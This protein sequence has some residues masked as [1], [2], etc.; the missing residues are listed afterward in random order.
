[1]DQTIQQ[2]KKQL[3]AGKK[4][5]KEIAD[6]SEEKRNK[7]LESYASCLVAN[8]SLILKANEKDMIFSRQQ[9]CNDAFLDR[10]N[11]TQ[12]KIKEMEDE[13]HRIS[14]LHCPIG[15]ELETKT[16]AN[17]VKLSKLL[18]PLGSILIIY[19]SRP[20]VTS[21]S[22]ALCLKSG[23]RVI[24]KGGSESVHTNKLLHTLYQDVLKQNNIATESAIFIPNSDRKIIK[25][26]VR[27]K[28]Y[29]DIIIP[30]GGYG[31]V[32]M[33][34]RTSLIPIL[35]H[36]AGGARIYVDKSADV[37]M[38]IDICVNSKTNRPATC[39][40]LDTLIVHENIVSAILPVITKIMEQKGV[41]IFGDKK[42]QR[43]GNF[44]YAKEKQWMQE[45]L[46]FTLA[47]K[48]VKDDKEALRFIQK[49]TKHH[50]EGIVAQNSDVIKQFV[51]SIDAAALCINCSTRLHD[52]GV[53]GMGAEMGIATGKLHARGPVGLRELLTYKW[54][55]KG[56]GQ[57]R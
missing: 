14:K 11:L 18:V 27:Q 15:E 57:I 23:N 31:L 21:Y 50:T 42:S 2:I 34:E 53:F 1:M 13:L 9:G 26:L 49:Y 29:I 6:F 48:I 16:L 46:S 39:N 19:E 47:I 55:L 41:K 20:D 25:W 3:L 45:F 7:I 8:T 30:R 51:D 4:S 37:K 43:Y 12:K 32:K 35:A 40:S 28:E 56:S 54:I 38:A 24:L 36:S 5:Q 52:G 33:I 17:G 44:E 22:L 10:L